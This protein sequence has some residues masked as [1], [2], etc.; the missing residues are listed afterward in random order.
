MPVKARLLEGL[1]SAQVQGQARVREEE[2]QAA[3][4]EQVVAADLARKHLDAAW[5]AY[6]VQQGDLHGQDAAQAG[7]RKQMP[8]GRPLLIV[9]WQST[10]T[11]TDDSRGENKPKAASL[12]QESN[13]P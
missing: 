1:V 7:P 6:G 9:Y 8:S 4:V 5:E 13:Q 3:K 11:V 2:V 10:A 12:Q